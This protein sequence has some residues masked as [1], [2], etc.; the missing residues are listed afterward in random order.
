MLFRSAGAG[1]ALEEQRALHGE[2]EVQR[3]GQAAVGDV[4]RRGE[5]LEGVVDG[6]G[7]SCGLGCGHKKDDIVVR[8]PTTWNDRLLLNQIGSPETKNPPKRVI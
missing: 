6:G 3:G 8:V 1:L 7:G 2:R 4:V 5:Q